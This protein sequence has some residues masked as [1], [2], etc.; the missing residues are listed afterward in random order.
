MPKMACLTC[1][2]PTARSRCDRCQAIRDADQPPRIRATAQQRGYD[3][4]WSKIRLQI[5]ARDNWVCYLCEKRLIGR[6]AT[7]DHVVA[8]ANGGSR[9]DPNNL[10]ACCLSCNSKKQHR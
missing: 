8:L 7:V 3:S 10:R 2:I 9:L 4:A 5:L 6:D 1:G